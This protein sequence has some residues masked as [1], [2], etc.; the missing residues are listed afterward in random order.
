MKR[1]LFVGHLGTAA[2]LGAVS[3]CAQSAPLPPPNQNAAARFVQAVHHGQA[4]LVLD[5]AAGGD[6]L[7]TRKANVT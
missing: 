4:G 1:R 2:V 3:G 6:T 5:G 7:A